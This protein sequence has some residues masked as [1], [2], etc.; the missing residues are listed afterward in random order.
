MWDLKFW[1]QWN[2]NPIGGSSNQQSLAGSIT[3]N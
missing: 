1:W 3:D 2:G